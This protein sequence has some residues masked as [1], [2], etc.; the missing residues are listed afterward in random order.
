MVLEGETTSAWVRRVL[1]NA[2]R[3]RVLPAAPWVF[4]LLILAVPCSK[5]AARRQE[6]SWIPISRPYKGSAGPDLLHPAAVLSCVP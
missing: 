3:P 1:P 6:A 4:Q 2:S 5:A